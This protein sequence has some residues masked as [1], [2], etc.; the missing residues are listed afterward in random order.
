MRAR[1]PSR[2]I[3]ALGKFTAKCETMV[4]TLAIVVKLES[5]I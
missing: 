3:G 1:P 5:V 4:M 2:I